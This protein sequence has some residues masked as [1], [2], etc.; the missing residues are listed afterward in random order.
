MG[1]DCSSNSE[2]LGYISSE[3]IEDYDFLMTV[4]GGEKEEIREALS[5][6]LRKFFNQ[7]LS[8]MQ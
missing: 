5:K 8:R 1:A 2:T 6:L 7:Y 3:L 4:T